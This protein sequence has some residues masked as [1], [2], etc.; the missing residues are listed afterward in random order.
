MRP[1][2]DGSGGGRGGVRGM[3][4]LSAAVLCLS[5]WL[6]GATVSQHGSQLHG[7]LMASAQMPPLPPAPPPPRPSAPAFPAQ[8]QPRQLDCQPVFPLSGGTE[9]VLSSVAGCYKLSNLAGASVPALVTAPSRVVGADADT[10]AVAV[11]AADRN[12]FAVVVAAGASL[13]LDGIELRDVVLF[14][15]P[16]GGSGGNSR[17]AGGSPVGRGTNTAVA[18][19]SFSAMSG[20]G[21]AEL[22]RRMLCAPAAFDVRVG[23]RLALK[24]VRVVAS[25]AAVDA[26]LT[27]LESAETFPPQGA[28]WSGVVRLQEGGFSLFAADTP[29]VTMRRVMFGC[30]PHGGA[31]AGVATSSAGGPEALRAGLADLSLLGMPAAVTFTGNVS[32]DNGWDAAAPFGTYLTLRG[33]PPGVQVAALGSPE[34]QTPQ[35]PMLNMSGSP[36]VLTLLAGQARLLVTDMG[37]G[38]GCVSFNLTLPVSQRVAVATPMGGVRFIT[39]A[40]ESVSPPGGILVRNSTVVVSPKEVSTIIYWAV[41]LNSPCSFRRIPAL[42]PFEQQFPVQSITLTDPVEQNAR[43]VAV[44]SMVAEAFSYEAVVFEAADGRDAARSMPVCGAA[45]ALGQATVGANDLASVNLQWC[46]GGGGGDGDGGADLGGRRRL[47]DHSGCHLSNLLGEIAESPGGPSPT[48]AYPV[49]VLMEGGQTVSIQPRL[50]LEVSR[51]L[52]LSGPLH[53]LSSPLGG[54]PGAPGGDGTRPGPLV[55]DLAGSV[56]SLTMVALRGSPSSSAP[57]VLQRLTLVNAAAEPLPGSSY[58]TALPLWAFGGDRRSPSAPFLHVSNVTLMLAVPDFVQL[59]ALAELGGRWATLAPSNA[60]ARGTAIFIV[61][62]HSKCHLHFD[63]YLGWGLNATDMRLEPTDCGASIALIDSSSGLRPPPPGLSE[64]EPGG[65]SQT[66]L[67]IGLGVGLGVAALLALGALLVYVM[68][69][70]ASRSA[71]Y[72]E[73]LS[74]YGPGDGGSSS[75]GVCGGPCSSLGGPAGGGPGGGNAAAAAAAVLLPRDSSSGRRS[76]RS[77]LPRSRPEAAAPAYAA[78]PSVSVALTG[79][80][81]CWSPDGADRVLAPTPMHVLHAQLPRGFPEGMDSAAVL[82][83]WKAVCVGSPRV[84]VGDGVGG[85]G[86]SGGGGGALPWSSRSND[87]VPRR[88]GGEDARHA[89]HTLAAAARQLPHEHALGSRDGAPHLGEASDISGTATDAAGGATAANAAGSAAAASAA[90]D[91]GVEAD[92]APALA[93]SKRRKMFD[94]LREVASMA[95]TLP[96]D[97]N[98]L[99][100]LE[101][102][103]RGGFGTVYRG[104]WRNLD[105]AIKT[106]MFSEAQDATGSGSGS[107]VAAHPQQRAIM[108]AAVCTSVMHPNIVTTYHYDIVPVCAG[109]ELKGSNGTT[110]NQGTTSDWKLYLVQESCNASLQDAVRNQLLLHRASQAPDLDLIL[111]LL[112]DIARGLVYI[113]SKSIIH[114]DLT[115]GNVLLK[116]ESTSPIG[117]MAKVTDFGLCTTVDPTK[118]HVSNVTNGTPFYVAPEVVK[119]GVTTQKSDVYSFGVLM[120]EMYRCTPPWVKTETGYAQ[121]KRFRRFPYNSPRV[122]VAL[123]ARCLDANP[124]QRPEFSEVLSRLDAMHAAFLQGYDALELPQQPPQQPLQHLLQ[125]PPQPHVALGVGAAARPHDTCGTGAAAALQNSPLGV[126]VLGVDALGVDARADDLHCL[127]TGV[128]LSH[129][130]AS[131]PMPPPTTPPCSMMNAAG[132]PAPLEARLCGA[133]PCGVADASGPP[134]GA[135]IAADSVPQPHS[136]SRGGAAPPRSRVMAEYLAALGPASSTGQVAAAL[137]P[138]SSPAPTPA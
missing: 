138:G 43:R 125:Q 39:S 68:R 54:D 42:L 37:I 101:Q 27:Y 83:Y 73:A 38:H 47:A 32:L 9:A 4:W 57:L 67:A 94:P 3:G 70:R 108:E 113:H 115:P 86:G 98:T 69:R 18:E 46:Y 7:L 15:P 14:A 30:R 40:G 63:T 120:W 24:N 13:E 81:D 132:V 56:R 119:L 29:S 93:A 10:A 71:G 92:A 104:R 100:L 90:A 21:A 41:V 99:V 88:S 134:A 11:T 62:H 129:I 89:A 58:R 107:R 74:K 106:V 102:I 5:L 22:A 114:G 6:Q 82:E 117:V 112:C 25:C 137:A 121:H 123:C 79:G 133:Q 66:A 35:K 75:G 76:I 65:S 44:A 131:L 135:V 84:G 33:G 85:S 20:D 1:T 48:S 51:G 64:Q 26:W 91:S 95:S 52:L 96:G 50:G 127:P 49:V 105:V 45:G 109:V 2:R 55:L 59:Y 128:P 61:D 97:D 136:A 23:G 19:T 87:A 34:L 126:D 77:Q 36:R 60:L 122:F 116:H 31:A 103:G 16:H 17:F 111:S 124:K 130:A 53:L 78:A 72:A 118:T 12:V 80:S 8:P 110:I 28:S